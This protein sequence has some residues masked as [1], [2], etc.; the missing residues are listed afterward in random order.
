MCYRGPWTSVDSYGCYREQGKHGPLF[1][2]R[3][4]GFFGWYR[5]VVCNT[6]V[7]AAETWAYLGVLFFVFYLGYVW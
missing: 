7:A 4:A 5:A 3:H 2:M 1:D 6:A